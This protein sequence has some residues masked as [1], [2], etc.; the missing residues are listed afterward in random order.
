MDMMI[1]FET[2][3]L[4]TRTAELRSVGLVAF[5][6]FVAPGKFAGQ[7]YANIDDP[8]GTR[9]PSTE[10][11]W[12]EQSPTAQAVFYFPPPKPV[13]LVMADIVQF[14]REHNIVHVWSHGSVF[15]IPL[16]EN[17]MRQFWQKVP[18]DFRAV[19]DTRTIY[20]AANVKPEPHAGYTLKHHAGHDAANQAYAV[21]LSYGLLKQTRMH[22]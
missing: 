13:A 14:C 3:S 1:D 6:P 15:D 19:Q 21:Q 18:W 5:D 7:Y 16:C 9:S 20:R 17:K 22:K 8:G 11:W 12:S 10:Q 2:W 4:D